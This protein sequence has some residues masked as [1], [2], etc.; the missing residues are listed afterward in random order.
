MRAISIAIK[1]GIIGAMTLAMVVLPTPQLTKR[2]VPT[3]GVHKPMQRLAMRT[4]PNCTGSM[5]KAVTTG[6]KIGVKIKTAGVMSMKV[7]TIRSS[8]LMRS[9]IMIGLSD[10][11]I[12]AA[13][14]VWGTRS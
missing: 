10:K 3:G 12:M 14:T 1:K 8:T 6:K 5:P 9:R 11:A 13:L 7:P 4:I 2:Q